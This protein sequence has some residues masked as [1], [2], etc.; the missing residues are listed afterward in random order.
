MFLGGI[1]G[2]LT[3]RLVNLTGWAELDPAL[4]AVVGVGS[5]LVAVVGVPLAAIALVFEVFG[6]SYGPPAILACGV[7][8]LL[9]LKI[10]IYRQQKNAA[11]SPDDET[12]RDPA[13]SLISADADAERSSRAVAPPRQ[14]ASPPD[15]V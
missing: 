4:F 9:T 5:S 6:K 1:S 10:R 2:A 14:E 15:D 12:D 11:R 3:A 13:A 8:Y 7:T